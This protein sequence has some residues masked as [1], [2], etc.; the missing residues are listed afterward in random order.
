MKYEI[1]V[2]GG[3]FS[4]ADAVDDILRNEETALTE[5]E[6]NYGVRVE[7]GSIENDGFGKLLGKVFI[8]SENVISSRVVDEL[9]QQFAG[10]G[11]DLVEVKD[12]AKS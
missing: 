10:L 5:L 11:F 9:A 12:E 3:M 1:Q 2:I 7:G 4:V 8:E 6:E